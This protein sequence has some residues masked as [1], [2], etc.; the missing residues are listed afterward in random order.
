MV[1]KTSHRHGGVI[2]NPANNYGHSE[3][4]SWEFTSVGGIATSKKLEGAGFRVPIGWKESSFS[5]NRP[6]RV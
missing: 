5:K 3:P 4:I 1:S 2:G 6:D